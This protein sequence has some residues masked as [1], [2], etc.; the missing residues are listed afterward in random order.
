MNALSPFYYGQKEIRTVK[1]GNEI[2]FVA[3]DICEGLDITWS[4]NTLTPI[5]AEWR[6]MLKFNTPR[7]N[8]DLVVISEAAVFI[9]R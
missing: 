3:K 6:R 7:G 4:G 1:I 9:R 2:W 8:Q 5:K